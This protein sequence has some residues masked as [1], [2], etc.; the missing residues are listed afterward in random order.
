MFIDQE[1]WWRSSGIFRMVSSS[2]PSSSCLK[3]QAKSVKVSREYGWKEMCLY[4]GNVVFNRNGKIYVGG[5]KWFATHRCLP[6]SPHLVDGPFKVT[7]PAASA[8]A[9]AAGFDSRWLCPVF[10]PHLPGSLRKGLE[11]HMCQS[12]TGVVSFQ[13]RNRDVFGT[14]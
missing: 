2:D 8:A 13:V 5:K 1:K 7:E 10:G 11:R 12:R 14:S 9:G 4:A 6:V 3:T